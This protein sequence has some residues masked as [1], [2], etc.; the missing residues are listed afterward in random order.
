MRQTRGQRY[1]SRVR[2][3]G[4]V[5]AHHHPLVLSSNN[6]RVRVRAGTDLLAASKVIGRR[7]NMRLRVHCTTCP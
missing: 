5:R 2:R 3:G 4:S 6:V 7:H 1:V